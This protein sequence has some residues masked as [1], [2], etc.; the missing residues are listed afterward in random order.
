MRQKAT[1]LYATIAAVA[2]LTATTAQAAPANL[3]KVTATAAIIVNRATG[4][5]LWERNADLPLPPASTTKV[6]TSLIALESARVNDTVRVSR[7]AAAAEP[8]KIYLR[9]GWGMRVDD[10]VYALMLKSANDAAEVVAEGL[11]GSVDGFGVRMTQKARA[12]GARSSVFRN[13]HGLPSE[14]HLSTARDLTVIFDAA[15]R[16]PRFRQVAMTKSKLI[17]PVTGGKQRIQLRTHNRFLEGYRVPVIGKTGYTRAA[18]RCFTGAALG[19]NGNEYLVTVLGSRDLWGDLGRMLDYALAGEPALGVDMQ[20]AAADSMD[21]VPPR[22]R[23]PAAAPRPQRQPAPAPAAR[24]A[25]RSRPAPVAR[26][27]V[28]RPSGETETLSIGDADE[29]I[30]VAQGHRRASQGRYVVQLATLSSPA[31]AEQL[32]AAAQ[33]KG[34]HATVQVIGPSNRRQ[35][36]VRVE[37]FASRT[38]AER[39]VARLRNA[40][41]QVR[42]IILAGDA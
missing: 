13:P 36:R 38:A 8:S 35:Y 33:R 14:G 3:S 26:V 5:V 31:R 24:P 41:T 10:L 23:Q 19:G 42:P 21:I 37:G 40:G 18:K 39:A 27:T 28:Q 34:Y 32:R 29:E 11:S 25:A 22:H 30:R 1:A 15:M 2:G 4:E 7:S 17:Q 16:N 6:L 20:M 12:L 9:P